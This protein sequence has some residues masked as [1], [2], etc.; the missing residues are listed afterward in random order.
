MGDIFRA[1]EEGNEEE[2]IRLLD[3][4]PALLERVDQNGDMPLAGAAHHGHLGV[5]GLLIERSAIINATGFRGYTALQYA[6][7]GGHEEMLA[8][9]LRAGAHAVTRDE[10]GITPLMLASGNGHL[11]VVKMLVQHMPG[12]G[13]DERSTCGLTA[14][15]YAAF[16][17][18]EEVVRFLLLAGA[19]PTITDNEGRTPRALAEENDNVLSSWAGRARSVAVFQVSPLT[20]GESA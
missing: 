12:Q 11:G 16:W 17:G 1:V 7:G 10:Y 4:D 14:L 2:V 5:V 8:L 18:H 9:L 13:L 20:C 15:H 3:A 19:D 6:A